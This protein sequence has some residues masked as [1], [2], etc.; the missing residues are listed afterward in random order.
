MSV[1]QM[2][3]DRPNDGYQ[4]DSFWD[5][6]CEIYKQVKS[7]MLRLQDNYQL[8]VNLLLFC[9]FMDLKQHTLSV[10]QWQIVLYELTQS[11]QQLKTLRS[12]RKAAK[13][14]SAQK[15]NALLEQELV[16]ERK[17]QH[18]IID[19]V[20]GWLPLPNGSDN[21]QAYIRHTLQTSESATLNDAMMTVTKVQRAIV[22]GLS[23]Q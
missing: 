12:R 11:E 9:C 10:T 13:S 2:T 17:Q 21:M 8:N 7:D 16:L 15:Y 3:N 5:F 1:Q 6:S 14:T 20:Q 19:A 23:H 18:Q 4:Y 22:K